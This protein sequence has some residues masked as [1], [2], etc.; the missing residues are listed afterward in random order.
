M[1]STE[2][3]SK[4]KSFEKKKQIVHDDVDEEG[5]RLYNLP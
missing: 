5:H 3:S 2:K 4:K 1:N